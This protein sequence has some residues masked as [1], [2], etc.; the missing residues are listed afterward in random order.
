MDMTLP[1]LAEGNWS[2]SS[3]SE[4]AATSLM[5]RLG[6]IEGEALTYLEQHETT[7]LRQ[8][9]RDLEWPSSLVMMAVGAL[10]RSKLVRATQLELEIVLEPVRAHTVAV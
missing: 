3:D 6:I 8:L 10:V 1:P 5:T 2:G 4:K 9:I 7:S